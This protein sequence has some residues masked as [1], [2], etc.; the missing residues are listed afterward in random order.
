MIYAIAGCPNMGTLRESQLDRIV[1][2]VT[3][4]FSPLW[5]K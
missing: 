1:R 3:Q 5:S 4:F 2:I